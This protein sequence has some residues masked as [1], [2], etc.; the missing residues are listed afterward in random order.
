MSKLTNTIINLKD[1]FNKKK[2]NEVEALS[3][4]LLIEYSESS[5]INLII[6][7][8]YLAKKKPTL[9]LPL[10]I[11][12]N[13]LNPT[14]SICLLNISICYKQ[15]K[16]IPEYKKYLD[17]AV[18]SDPEN[19]EII[20][21]LGFFHLYVSEISTSISYYEKALKYK[22]NDTNFILN[23]SESY[24]R[25]GYSLKVI[26]ICLKYIHNGNVNSYV[27][28]SLAVAYKH[29]GDFNNAKL[30]LEESIKLSPHYFVAHRNLSSLMHYKADDKHLIQME[31]L[32]KIYPTNIDL[33]LALSKAYKDIKNIPKYFKHLETSNECKKQELKFDINEEKNKFLKIKSIFNSCNLEHLSFKDQPLTPIFI[34]GL[35][36]SG[37]TLTENIV[38]SHSKVFAG[39]ELDGFQ[40]L[41]NQ[42]LNNETINNFNN[43]NLILKFREHY[44]KSLPKLDK[45]VLYITDKMP[46]NFL[47]IGLIIKCFP[48]AKIINLLRSPVATCWSIYN[49]YFSSNGN[50]FSY[51]QSDIYEYY[52]LYID[53]MKHWNNMYS[54]K[55]YL[56]DYELLTRNPKQEIKK[57]LKYCELSVEKDCFNPHLNKRNINTA[58]SV[59]AREK[60]YAGSSSDWEIYKEFI[61]PK[62]LTLTKNKGN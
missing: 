62:I 40:N 54:N 44:L 26:E 32:L 49:T 13:K 46:L 15:L 45:E 11:K 42:V 5:E 19:L 28:N 55:I 21:E 17:L 41:G 4:S 50:A 12:A 10:L 23:L 60:I 29:I 14:S 8:S 35:P 61:S 3:K 56:L 58:S 34:L 24:L 25:G 22:I 1:L 53:L 18:L 52:N 37:T 48:N 33:N 30:H 51:D 27:F 2:F 36:R 47:W 39:G 31:S 43:K 38:S 59:Q 6:G 16:I 7:T 20:C 57:L 9:A